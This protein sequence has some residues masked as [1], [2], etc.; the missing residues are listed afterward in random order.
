MTL[1]SVVV[2]VHNG[3]RYLGDALQSVLDQTHA[4]LEVI[5]VDDGSTDRSAG[6]AKDFGAAIHLVR[7]AHMGGGAARNSGI[8]RARGQA[9]ALLDADDVWEP[10]KLERQLAALDEEPQLD[11]VF[12]HAAEFVSGDRPDLVGRLV[13]RQ[14][15][16]AYLTSALLARAEAV[17][18]VGP[19]ATHV[20]LGEWLDWYARASERGLRHRM[21]AEVLVRRRLHAGNLGV[22]HRDLRSEYA[23]VL[24]A[25]LDRRRAT[26]R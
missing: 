19:F 22:S 2:P 10:T 18:A 6:V 1:V 23:L 14:P 3:E 15:G 8:Q 20:T 16:P 7:Q 24:K 21:L 12:T 13:P 4:D 11:L 17:R 25:A 9:L 5:V 26:E